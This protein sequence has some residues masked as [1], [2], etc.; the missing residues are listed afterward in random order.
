MRVELDS[1]RVTCILTMS[2][3]GH[4]YTLETCCCSWGP[5]MT[6]TTAECVW[7]DVRTPHHYYSTLETGNNKTFCS[8]HRLLYSIVA[9][10]EGLFGYKMSH[11]EERCV[12][13]SNILV[14]YLCS[15]YFNTARVYI[16]V[17][18][19]Q[20]ILWNVSVCSV[21]RR[22]LYGLVS[23]SRKQHN[24]DTV[25]CYNSPKNRSIFLYLLNQEG[26]MPDLP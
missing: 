26:S 11:V 20:Q 4:R 2:C 5:G 6:H 3:G 1:G 23:G 16:H 14:C 24:C 15:V 13:S 22:K 17:N 19:A 10:V 25:H 8:T 12:Y 21:L 18:E 7:C 9:Y